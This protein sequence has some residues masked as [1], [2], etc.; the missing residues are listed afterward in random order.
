VLSTTGRPAPAQPIDLFAEVRVA[1]NRYLPPDL[2]APGA[3]GGDRWGL[4]DTLKR[5]GLEG[6]DTPHKTAMRKLAMTATE[7]SWTPESQ[8]DLQEYNLDDVRKTAQ[9]FDRMFTSIDWPQAR[10]R[11]LYTVAVAAIEHAG[12]PIDGPLYRQLLEAWEGIKRL[13]IARLEAEY[14]WQFHVDGSFNEELFA[15][16]L[17]KR[18]GGMALHQRRRVA[19]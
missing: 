15:K 5:Y 2:R 1:F 16:W 18:G 17:V 6:G 13:L 9:L 7:S 8:R 19:A 3:H 12:I 11:G 14:C 10:L 4:Y